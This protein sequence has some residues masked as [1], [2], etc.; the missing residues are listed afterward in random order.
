MDGF[1]QYND[2]PAS[3]ASYTNKAVYLSNLYFI[4]ENTLLETNLRYDDY[5]AFDN[6]TTYKIGLKHDH[7]FLEGFATSANYYSAYD[8]PS[9]YQ[10]ANTALGSFLKPSYTKGF[11]VT[12]RY[13]KLLTL[14]YFNNTVEDFVDYDMVNFGYYNVEGTS[15]FSGFEV[16]SSY[17]PITPLL[18][19]ANYTHL[20]DFEKEDGSNLPRRAKDTLNASA[21]YYTDNNIHFGIDAQY[22]GDRLDTDGGFPIAAEVPTGNYT[23]W[24]L[25]FGAEIAKNIDLNIHARNIFDKDYQSVYSYATEGA[26]VYAKLTYSF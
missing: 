5:D 21:T 25:N 12:A 22:I 8:A 10:L 1:N 4:N 14:S 13:K 19:S 2:F 23:L 24:N 15:K 9:S 7:N 16:T 6:K 18:L 26:S 11:D 17:A 3:Q 20:I